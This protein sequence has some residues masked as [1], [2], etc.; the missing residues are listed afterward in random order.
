MEMDG[1][2]HD[3]LPLDDKECWLLLESILDCA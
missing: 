2:R 3:K 1:H